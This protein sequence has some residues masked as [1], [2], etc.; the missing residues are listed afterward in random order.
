MKFVD[1]QSQFAAYEPEIRREIEEVL[2][3][4]QFIM[5][6]KGSGRMV[7]GQGTRSLQ[8]LQILCS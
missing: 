7:P 4:A 6:P 1:L 3:G 2:R 5:G 8:E